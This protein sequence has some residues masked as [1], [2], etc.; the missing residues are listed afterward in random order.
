[1]ME[2]PISSP[3]DI[4]KKYFLGDDYS[5]KFQKTNYG[6]KYGI[7]HEC[8]DCNKAIEVGKPLIRITKIEK[9]PNTERQF[10]RTWLF[11]NYE[12]LSH[13][14]EENNPEFML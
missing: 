2:Q 14:L 1:M 8:K 9:I 10:F 6:D 11:C 3:E 13:W 7:P 12:H 5:I 4:K